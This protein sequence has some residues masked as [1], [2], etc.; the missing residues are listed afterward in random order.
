VD[1]GIQRLIVP[2]LALHAALPLV[3]WGLFVL[4]PD[5]AGMAWLAVHLGFPVLLLATVRWWRPF[6]EDLLLL[7]FANHI[8]TFVVAALLMAAAA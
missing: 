7:V 4:S 5:A 1:Q 2:S 3:L 6:W 8:V